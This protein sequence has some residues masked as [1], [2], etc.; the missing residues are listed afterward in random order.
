V[1]SELKRQLFIGTQADGLERGGFVCGRESSGMLYLTS[2]TGSA[3]PRTIRGVDH[4]TLP[5]DYEWLILRAHWGHADPPCG[6]YHSH[7]G[8]SVEPSPADI[9]SWEAG[10]KLTG[11]PWVGI[12]VT[13]RRGWSDPVLHAWVT[14]TDSGQPVT[15]PATAR[16]I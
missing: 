14:R 7:P 8:G 1:R 2:V 10:H 5:D 11:N 6:N 4:M 3:D 16:W 9:Q 13:P 15:E 12:I